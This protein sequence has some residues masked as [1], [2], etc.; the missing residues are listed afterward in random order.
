MEKPPDTGELV[1]T[2]G[3][4]GAGA[5]EP[6]LAPAKSRSHDTQ[7]VALLLFFMLQC[8]QRF[9]NIPMLYNTTLNPIGMQFVLRFYK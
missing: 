4:D 5:T 1:G 2:V 6:E 8:V 7:N 3:A 9:E